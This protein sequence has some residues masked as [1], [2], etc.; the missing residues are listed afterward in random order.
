VFSLEKRYHNAHT[1]LQ[2]HADATNEYCHLG[3]NIVVEVMKQFINVVCDCFEV[4]C[5]LKPTYENLEQL[6]EINFPR[7]RLEAWKKYSTIWQR[8]FQ[9]KDKHH[10]IV[11]KAIANQLL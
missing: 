1:S 4:E 11:L 6:V 10:N 3:N 9:D 7:G 5:L 8:P 2:C